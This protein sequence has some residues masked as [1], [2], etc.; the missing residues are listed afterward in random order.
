M[1]NTD[2]AKDLFGHFSQ[3]QSCNNNDYNLNAALNLALDSPDN[4]ALNEMQFH[5][6]VPPNPHSNPILN[7]HDSYNA[8]ANNQGYRPS[9][10]VTD[11]SA[12]S[13]FLSNNSSLQH[14]SPV[15]SALQN[16]FASNFQRGKYEEV[17]ICF[18][19][20][21]E[22]IMKLIFSFN[23][24]LFQ[25]KDYHETSN[26]N[27]N[28]IV[29]SNE[30]LYMKQQQQ[31]MQQQNSRTCKLDDV[32]ALAAEQAYKRLISNYPNLVD[33]QQQQQYATTNELDINTGM[34]FA[35]A[36]IFKM[37]STKGSNAGVGAA[38]SNR[39]K[40]VFSPIGYQRNL[41]AAAAAA[42]ATREVEQMQQ[43]KLNYQTANDC[44]RFIVNNADALKAIQQ[45]NCQVL[46]QLVLQMQ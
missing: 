11:L 36:A 40:Q 42:A 32:T 12:D 23:S 22:Q 6:N 18:Y 5:C 28:N 38:K 33:Q 31:Q 15:E 19:S 34:S 17:C 25:Y 46:V 10:T 26:L 16:C 30:Q 13:G 2:N 4:V 21:V 43:A 39:E 44:Q 20:T 29:A 45:Q 14:F 7:I 3:L 41:V 1:L 37:L 27:V 8:T 35:D 9:S 24:F